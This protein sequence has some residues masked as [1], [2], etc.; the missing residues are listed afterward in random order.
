MR[1]T[2]IAHASILV[3]SNGVSVLSDPWWKGP[4]YGAQWW[5]YPE[6]YLAA[7]ENEK[8]DYIYISHGHHDHFHPTTLK[9]F[10]R[11]IRVLI[12][13][14]SDLRTAIRALGF[15]VIEVNGEKE[16][17]LSDSITCR[18]L[19]TVGGDSLMAI[20]DGTETCLNLNDSLHASSTVV[21]GKFVDLLRNFYRRLDYVFCGYGTASHFPNCY[22]IPGKDKVETARMRQSHFNQSWAEVI[23]RL[24]PRFAFPFA[25]D[26]V[27]LEEDLFWSN[28]AI[29]N[30]ER[31]T[32]VC[33]RLYPGSATVVADIAPGFIIEKGK[34]LVNK[35]RRPI[36]SETLRTLYQ[37]SI[38]RVNT[39]R[40]VD[41]RSVQEAVDLIRDNIRKSTHYFEMFEEDYKF[42]VRF[43]NSKAGIEI[44][45]RSHELAVNAVMSDLH[46]TQNYDLIYTTR[47][48]YFKRSLT[49]AYGH[50]TLF[51]GSG[52]IFEY[53]SSNRIGSRL[54]QELID[55][56][57]QINNPPVRRCSKA[58][59]LLTTAKR[60]LKKLVSRTDDHLYDLQKWTVFQTRPV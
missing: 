45:K 55:M 16:H 18:I 51:V 2:F 20:S 9:Q 57:R 54:H 1:V 48:Q 19:P 26:V 50:E 3:Q 8:I 35:I 4:C 36:C 13:K 38:N 39:Q 5:L 24:A 22:V 25:A 29:H 52:G 10:S 15:Q 7:I 37:D 23:Q 33:K 28:E 41:G 56:V 42:L 59:P 31:P 17:H 43:K 14:E 53:T 49:S 60:L 32:E 30:G 11:D 6:P 34:I 40:P 21:Q 46:T 12:P 44:V 27:L 58:K 47:M